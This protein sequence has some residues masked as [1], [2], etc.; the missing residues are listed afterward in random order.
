MHIF[1]ILKAMRYTE[2]VNTIR[3]ELKNRFI[4]NKQN[5]KEN[6]YISIML[7]KEIKELYHK[8]ISDKP[9]KCEFLQQV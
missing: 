3:N 5:E 2:T 7:H 8:S 1:T 4:D 6:I 9:I